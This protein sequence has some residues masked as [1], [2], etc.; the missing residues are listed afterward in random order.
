MGQLSYNTQSLKKRGETAVNL[1]DLSRFAETYHNAVL[2]RAFDELSLDDQSH[3]EM[4]LHDV[5]VFVNEK[6]ATVK[7]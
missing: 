2:Y 4:L 5:V 3:L 6:L 1:K 7:K